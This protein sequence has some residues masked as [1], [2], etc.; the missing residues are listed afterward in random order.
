VRA[1]ADDEHATRWS[2]DDAALPRVVW[3][4]N[5]A[6]AELHSVIPAVL[7]VYYPSGCYTNNIVDRVR[8]ARIS[9]QLRL[10]TSFVVEELANAGLQ[11][12]L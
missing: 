7:A 8:F 3:L 2:D 1:D 5:T 6:V 9:A 11:L 12:L 4:S 10:P